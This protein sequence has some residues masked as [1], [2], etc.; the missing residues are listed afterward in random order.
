M[1]VVMNTGVIPKFA[2]RDSDIEGKGL[3][4]TAAIPR[5]AVVVEWHPKALTLEEASQLPADVQKKYIYTEGEAMLLM[6]SPE[7]YMNHS[8]QANTHAVGHSDVASKNIHIGDEITSNYMKLD[9]EGAT[10]NCGASN[11]RKP[12]KK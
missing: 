4:A 8:C 5:G 3:F 12:S 1:M 10:C 11:C 6:Q 9:A 7:R 2:V